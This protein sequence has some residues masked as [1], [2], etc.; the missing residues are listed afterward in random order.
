MHSALQ[1]TK[2][3]PHPFFIQYLQQPDE[4]WVTVIIP[5]LGKG[6]WGT[7]RLLNLLKATQLSNPHPNPLTPN[8]KLKSLYHTALQ[9]PRREILDHLQRQQE[10]LPF[11]HSQQTMALFSFSALSGLWCGWLASEWFCH[12]SLL[13]LKEPR[14]FHICLIYVTDIYL[15]PRMVLNGLT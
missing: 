8:P 2:H 5:I 15:S 14:N 13:P 1:F 4:V 12:S 7:E 6:N 9:C 3:F 10:Q 11:L